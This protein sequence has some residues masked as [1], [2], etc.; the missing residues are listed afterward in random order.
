MLV[1]RLTTVLHAAT[2]LADDVWVGNLGV[3]LGERRGEGR[4]GGEGGACRGQ[5]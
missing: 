1:L 5:T 3:D 4:E 2:T